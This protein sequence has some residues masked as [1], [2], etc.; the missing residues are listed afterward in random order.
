MLCLLAPLARH[1]VLAG[2]DVTTRQSGTLRRPGMPPEEVAKADR[3]IR[4]GIAFFS[5]GRHQDALAEFQ[6][7]VSLCR[8]HCGKRD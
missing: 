6:S 5:Q 3:L 4:K 1:G 2:N 7:L 8:R